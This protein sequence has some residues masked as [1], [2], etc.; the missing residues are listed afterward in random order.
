MLSRLTE[1]SKMP[2][3]SGNKQ[4]SYS[5]KSSSNL[6]TGSMTSH[7]TEETYVLASTHREPIVAIVERSALTHEGRVRLADYALS[8]VIDCVVDNCHVDYMDAVIDRLIVLLAPHHNAGEN[9]PNFIRLK[10]LWEWHKKH[11]TDR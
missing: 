2:V 8:Y 5:C 6:D 11:R 9:I 1:E 3:R 7:K 4:V 10:K